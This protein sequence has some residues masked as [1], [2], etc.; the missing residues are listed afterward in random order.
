MVLGMD[1]LEEQNNGKMW[2]D[3]CRKTLRFKHLGKHITLRGVK[4]NTTHCPR[5]SGK[6]LQHLIEENAVAHLV[7]LSL[8]STEPS[9]NTIPPS[10]KE[11]ID[12]NS[13]LFKEPMELPPHRHCDHQIPLIPGAAP[14]HKKAYRYSP[15]QKDEIEKQI[16]DMVNRRIVQI[17]S[18]PHASPV[19]LDKKKDGGWRL[20]IDYRHLNALTVKNKSPL[21]IVDELLDEL[22]GA[23]WFTK[24]DLRSGYHQIRLVPGE[25]HKTAFKT[26]HGHWEF[27]VMPFGLTNALATFQNAMNSLFAHMIR[28]S[29]LIFMDDILIYSTSLQDHKNHLQEVFSIPRVNKL[30]VK[31]TKCSFSQPKLEYLGHVISAEGVATDPEKIKAVQSWP[32]PTN[33]K[34]LRGFLGLSGYYRKFI[35]GY[36]TISKP[37][38]ELLKKNISFVWSSTVNEAFLAL[39]EALVKAPLLALPDFSKPFMLHTDASGVGIGAVFHNMGILLLTLVRH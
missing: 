36:G 5:V 21:P 28:R 23:C 22:A 1:W 16:S 37:L 10:I 13:E 33:I 3:W 27:K 14:F 25:E 34:Q 26:H 4:D 19:I 8:I 9:E 24:L 32:T 11:V 15:T 17:S 35:Q 38:T 39:K 20:C 2:V 6:Q 12:A 31:S 30:F 18:S 7:Q 29:V